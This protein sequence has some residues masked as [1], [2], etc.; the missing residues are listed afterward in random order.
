MTARLYRCERCLYHY[1]ASRM[2]RYRDVHYSERDR[3][4]CRDEARCN[5][6][7]ARREADRAALKR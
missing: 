1:P 2:V 7:I 5:R 6:N 4:I 3:Y